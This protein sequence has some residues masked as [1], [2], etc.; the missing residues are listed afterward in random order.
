MIFFEGYLH[1]C[2]DVCI[3]FLHQ[4]V[5]TMSFGDKVHIICQIILKWIFGWMANQHCNE[6]G[7]QKCN[8]CKYFFS[9]FAVFTDLYY[10]AL[11]GC[12]KPTIMTR[13]NNTLNVIHSIPMIIWI[14]PKAIAVFLLYPLCH[15]DGVEPIT[16]DLWLFS[17]YWAVIWGLIFVSNIIYNLIPTLLCIK[18]L[19]SILTT[20]IVI[21]ETSKKFETIAG[22]NTGKDKNFW[23]RGGIINLPNWTKTSTT[24]NILDK[25]SVNRGG[26]GG[27]GGGVWVWGAGGRRRSECMWRRWGGFW[28]VTCF[29][30]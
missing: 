11:L 30:I 27:V 29:W 18:L 21:Y 12:R 7:P 24:H 13:K 25:I 16:M 1:L 10:M 6:G 9:I 22:Q 19:P 14:A 26:G 4:L 5:S 28:R 23:L 20:M 8:F 3:H 2:R 17:K 15:V